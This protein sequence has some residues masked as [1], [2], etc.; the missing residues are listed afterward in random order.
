MEWELEDPGGQ[1]GG[2][3][4]QNLFKDEI[5][6]NR[7]GEDV[8]GPPGAVFLTDDVHPEDLFEDRGGLVEIL[9]V[10]RELNETVLALA[11]LAAF[12]QEETD[13]PQDV[14]SN[15]DRLGQADV[16]PGL[17]H[18]DRCVRRN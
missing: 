15:D 12:C 14:V 17:E 5:Q 2:H 13:Q 4:T 11:N 10:R 6:Q 7:M 3:N 9:L 1:G 18:P 8:G 16:R